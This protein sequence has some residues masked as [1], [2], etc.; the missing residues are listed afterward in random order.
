MCLPPPLNAHDCREILMTASRHIKTPTMTVPL[1]KEEGVY[2]KGLEL[3][4][5]LT[6][7]LLS[8]V[9]FAVQHLHSQCMLVHI[10]IFKHAGSKGLS[11]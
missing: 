9:R 10:C 7:V 11:S 4:K 3:K 2:Q 1:L 6:R 5:Q 8:D